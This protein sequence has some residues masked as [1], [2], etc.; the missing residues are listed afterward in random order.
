MEKISSL[1]HV[2]SK[3]GISVDSVKV[4]AVTEWK[5][6]ENLTEVRSFLGL[7]GYYH[8]F[9][10]DFLKLGGPLTELTK[11]HC[12]FIW[13]AKCEMGFQELKKRVTRTPVPALL[14]G[15]KNFIVYT[16]ASRERLGCVLMQNG[17][18]IAFA[19]RKLKPHEQ[20][21]LTYDLELAAVVFA[22]KK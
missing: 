21:Y 12:K 16:D 7:A 15:N 3:D 6:L 4:E 19:S 20:N 13:N 18:V 14:N 2:I 11:K 17:H 8:R 9:I 22:L 5:Q 1:R 10:K